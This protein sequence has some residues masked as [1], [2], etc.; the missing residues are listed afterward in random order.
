MIIQSGTPG[1]LYNNPINSYVANFFGETNKFKGLVQNNY[2]ET[3]IGKI[4]VSRNMENQQ[5]EIHVRPQAIKL[6]QEQTPV[7]G[8]KGTV[9]A[10]FC[11]S[12]Q[13]K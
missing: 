7:N 12:I 1:Q 6:Q 4:K 5:V 8:V 11:L 2:V 3:P 9:V 10:N 13:I